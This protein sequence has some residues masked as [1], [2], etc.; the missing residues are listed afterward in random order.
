MCRLSWNLGTSTCWNP[1]GLSRPVIRLLYLFLYTTIS[2]L[3][4]VP[5]S[6]SP[7]MGTVDIFHWNKTVVTWSYSTIAEVKNARSYT[8]ISSDAFMSWHLMKIRNNS[9]NTRNNFFFAI[10]LKIPDREADHSH[11]SRIEVKNAWSCNSTSTCIFLEWCGIKH[12]IFS[13]RS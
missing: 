9:M 8:S 4:V 11:P 3:R 5:L 1:L 6:A 13:N 7:S 12:V 10:W 2:R